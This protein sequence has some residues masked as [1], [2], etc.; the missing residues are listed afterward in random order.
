MTL[1]TVPVERSDPC[2]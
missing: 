1:N 2:I